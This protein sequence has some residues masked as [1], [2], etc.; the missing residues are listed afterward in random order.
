VGHSEGEASELRLR[1]VQ[2]VL[3]TFLRGHEHT[4]RDLPVLGGQGDA[5]DITAVLGGGLHGL[6][7][8]LLLA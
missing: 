5:L 7:E 1:L 4:R 8:F 6:V 3:P 2:A